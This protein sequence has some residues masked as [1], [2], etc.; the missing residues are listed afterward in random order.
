MAATEQTIK[1]V[2]NLGNNEYKYGFSTDIDDIKSPKGLSEETVKFI[3]AQ[4]N[5]PDWMLEWRLNAF[6]VFNKL[7]EPNWAK[8]DIPKIDFQDYYY[9]SS[10][11]SLKDKPKSL[12][13]IDPDILKTYEKLGIPL[14]EQ[15]ILSGVAVDAVLTR[16]Q[17]PLHIKNN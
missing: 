8:L 5:E 3:S 2:N 16:S 9:Y 12:D 14:Q 10:P 7:P 11:K 1:Q 13:E 15:K 6:K 4:K 17:L